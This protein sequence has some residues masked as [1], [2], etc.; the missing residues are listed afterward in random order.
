MG[1]L[2]PKI[3]FFITGLGGELAMVYLLLLLVKTHINLY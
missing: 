1:F 2:I 3:A